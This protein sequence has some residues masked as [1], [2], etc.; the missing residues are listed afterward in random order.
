MQ[1]LTFGLK[2]SQQFTTVDVLRQVWALAD[3]GGFDSCWVFDHFASMG[4]DRTGDIFEA[5]TLLAAMAE[6]TRRLRI[7]CLV[8]GVTNRH[9]AV[10]A[11]MAVTVDHLSAGRLNLGIGAGGDEYVDTMFGLP[12]LSPPRERV[13]RLAEACQVIK[14]LWTEPA[15]TFTGRHYRMENAVA[16]PKPVQQPRPPISIASNGERRGLR[17]VAEHADVWITAGLPGHENPAELERLSH[18]LDRHCEA[19]GRDPATIRRLVQFWLPEDADEALR[20]TEVYV[21]AGFTD[22]V[23]APYVRGSDAIGAAEAAVKLLPR[24]RTLG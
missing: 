17:I 10:L 3:D 1:G 9:P 22:L 15:T 21:R 2:T 14:A 12:P 23:L 18:V 24:L 16:S 19:I 6:V 4:P 13:E 8:T 7:G 20:T 11:K 5:W